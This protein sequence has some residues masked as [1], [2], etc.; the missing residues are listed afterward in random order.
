MKKKSISVAIAML[1][2]FML[3]V[4]A[5]AVGVWGQD[6]ANH[7]GDGELSDGIVTYD[8]VS[9]TE[10]YSNPLQ[11]MM[12]YG[13]GT[14]S[15]ASLFANIS[16]DDTLNGAETAVNP[17]A[18]IGGTDERMPVNPTVLPYSAIVYLRVYF[19]NGAS[20][21]RGTGVIL[22][23]DLIL[24]AGHVVYSSDA[25]G[26]ASRIEV[27]AGVDGTYP[28]DSDLST[29][30]V[31]ITIP[32]N[33]KDYRAG[34]YDWG[35]FTTST[36]IGLSQG[37]L[38]FDQGQTSG[39]ISVTGYPSNVSV[40]GVN[41]NDLQYAMYTAYGPYQQRSD[42]NRI[43]HYYIDASGGQSGAP[44]YDFNSSKVIGVHTGGHT[45]GA[46]PNYGV[47]ITWDLYTY[48]QSARQEGIDKW[49]T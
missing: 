42:T 40:P 3:I 28:S 26:F 31:K 9:Q 12:N 17:C 27:Y 10:V 8:M 34:E 30:G 22:G 23:P 35:Y 6:G 2:S 21:A 29:T 14:N 49:V 1:L 15:P 39:N 20:P 24:T 48:L 36:P 47:L 45:G 25:G 16:N 13:A 4:Q 44:L 33:Y 43:A 46:G 7:Y 5:G 41:P 32:T 19:P 37:Y 38:S 18:L 11:S